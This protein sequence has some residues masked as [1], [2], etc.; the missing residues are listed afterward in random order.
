MQL[1]IIRHAIAQDR[2]DFAKSGQE[3]GERPLTKAGRRKMVRGA[4]GLR[5]MAPAIDVLVT[6]PLAR[7]AQTADIVADAYGGLTPVTIG[8][9]APEGRYA[10]FLRWLRSQAGE[11]SGSETPAG[12]D[13]APADAGEDGNG[14][15]A[16][17]EVV[18][19][20]GHEPHLRGLVSLL[21]TGQSTPIVELK[22]GAACLLDL[23]DQPTAGKAR[24]LWSLTP[25]QLRRLRA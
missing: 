25:A 4:R 14:R 17:P 21:L 24:L 16:P 10:D 18:A 13:G 20:V 1:L 8:E 12:G 5:R 15:A 11:G 9:L 7:A 2:E 19:A 23:G 6:S 22:K 3:D